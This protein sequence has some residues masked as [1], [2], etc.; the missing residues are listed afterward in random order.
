M[1]GW[2]HRFD[3]HEFE[4]A[5]QVGDGQESLTCCYPWGRK[6]S[7]TTER[8]NRLNYYD[9]P[10]VRSLRN[11]QNQ[12]FPIALVEKAALKTGFLLHLRWES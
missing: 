4:Q 10:S 9:Y 7:D 2:D 11:Q 5:L 6:E 8:L 3:G 12:G 1:V